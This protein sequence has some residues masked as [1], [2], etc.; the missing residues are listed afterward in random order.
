M[1]AA[2]AAGLGRGEAAAAAAAAV[3]RVV[4]LVLAP[5]CPL[6]PSVALGVRLVL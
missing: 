5:C 2:R 6:P 4:M 3:E 1:L